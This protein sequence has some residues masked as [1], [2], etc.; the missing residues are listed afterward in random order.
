LKGQSVAIHIENWPM[1]GLRLT[2][3]LTVNDVERLVD[4]IQEHP[5]GDVT[6][7]H[8]EDLTSLELDAARVLKDRLHGLR[9][10]GQARQGFYLHVVP[11]DVVDSLLAAGF[12]KAGG[13]HALIFMTPHS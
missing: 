11:G 7:I 13:E 6:A 3:Y 10:A 9:I 1:R 4:A 2:G 5:E 8:L 12:E